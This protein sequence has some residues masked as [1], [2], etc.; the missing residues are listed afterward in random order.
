MEPSGTPADGPHHEE[1]IKRHAG[2]LGGLPVGERGLGKA[3]GNSGST[4]R[5][6]Y[7]QDLG[8]LHRHKAIVKGRCAHSVSSDAPQKGLNRSP[9]PPQEDR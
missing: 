3:V 7:A 4:M 1:S 6:L 9:N 2:A 5:S 8:Y